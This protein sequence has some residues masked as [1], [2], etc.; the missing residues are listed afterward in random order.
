MMPEM[1]DAGTRMSASAGRPDAV[2]FDACGTLLD[3]L[4]AALAVHGSADPGLR[5]QPL[6]T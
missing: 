1:K 6:A 3:D 4:H 2:V 5:D